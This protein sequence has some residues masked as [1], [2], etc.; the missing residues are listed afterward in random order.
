MV[1]QQDSTLNMDMQQK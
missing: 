1:V